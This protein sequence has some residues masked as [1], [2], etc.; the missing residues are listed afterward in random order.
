V[1][2]VMVRRNIAIFII[3]ELDNRIYILIKG[4]NNYVCSNIKRDGMVCYLLG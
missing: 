1:K 2:I 4:K 3:F